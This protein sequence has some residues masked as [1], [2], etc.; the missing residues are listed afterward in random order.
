MPLPAPNAPLTTL[1]GTLAPGSHEPAPDGTPVHDLADGDTLP[2]TAEGVE[3]VLRVVHTPGHTPDSLCLHYP[4]DRALFTADTVL[5]H[6]SA[7][8]ED[9]GAY[10]ASLRKMIDYCRAE[11]GA[12]TYDTVY[13]GHGP[14]VSDGLAKIE[15]YLKH[16]VEREEQI[17]QVL[18]RPA[19]Q[20][21]GKGLAVEDIV[22]TIYAKYPKELWG[23]AAHSVGL[24][25]KK[26]QDDGRVENVGGNWVLLG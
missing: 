2:I 21:E 7:V 24:H 22:A 23:P 9:L 26:L 3:V 25:L 20:E 18:E 19:V 17:V 16:R 4:P 5:G 11:G 6:G 12:P 1:L 10:M 8:F 13:P 15:M 14:V